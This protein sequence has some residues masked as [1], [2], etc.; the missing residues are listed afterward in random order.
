MKRFLGIGLK[1]VIWD[2]KKSGNE[3]ERS[4]VSYLLRRMPLL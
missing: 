2:L 4:E 1:I 3:S